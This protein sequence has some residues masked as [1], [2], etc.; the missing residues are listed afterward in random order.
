MTTA[1]QKN[2]RKI[3]D[4]REWSVAQ[5]ERKIGLSKQQSVQNIFKGTSKNPS[6]ELVYGISKALNISIEELLTDAEHIKIEN[7]DL[8]SE[9]CIKVINEIKNSNNLKLSPKNLFSI[10]EEVYLYNISMNSTAV[11]PTFIKWT[12][13]KYYQ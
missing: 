5:L 1:L 7:Y 6:I 4:E 9:V 11:D 10:I 2:L 12:I 13:T 3:L 8:F